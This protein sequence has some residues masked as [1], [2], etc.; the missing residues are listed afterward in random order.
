M[1][2]PW[3]K[4][5]AATLSARV[6]Q[7]PKEGPLNKRRLVLPDGRRGLPCPAFRLHLPPTGPRAPGAPRPSGESSSLPRGDQGLLAT[8]RC[9]GQVGAAPPM[10]LDVS[11]PSSCAQACHTAGW[12]L[13]RALPS[14]LTASDSPP[15]AHPRCGVGPGMAIFPALG[16]PS[17][18]KGGSRA[19]G[20]GSLS[21]SS[22]HRPHWGESAQRWSAAQPV[23][24]EGRVAGVPPREPRPFSSW[25]RGLEPRAV[26]S[27]AASGGLCWAQPYLC[28]HRACQGGAA[29]Q[30][31]R[32][33][34][35]PG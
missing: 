18:P 5:S 8:S 6:R 12:P 1:E 7:E 10:P 23:P 28:P 21:T 11:R 35:G 32:A 2:V 29:P 19:Q 22:A 33:S 27:W 24:W 31:S 25:R 3:T 17:A 13:A 9:H 34:Q 16:S 4:A 14:P 20:R 15:G 30:D 26:L